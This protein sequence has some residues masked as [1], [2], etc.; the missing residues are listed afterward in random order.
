MKNKLIGWDDEKIYFYDETGKEYCVNDHNELFDKI[1]EFCMEYF[2][3][4]VEKG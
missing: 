1:V 2:K 3:H 4:K